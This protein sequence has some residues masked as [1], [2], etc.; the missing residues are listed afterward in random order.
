MPRNNLAYDNSY[1]GLTDSD[2]YDTDGI[3]ATDYVV[4]RDENYIHWATEIAKN[5]LA[6]TELKKGWNSYNANRIDFDNIN[7]AY[8][9]LKDLYKPGLLPPSIIPTH[10]GSI[11]LEW[12]TTDADLEI[13]IVDNF[14]F[15][16]FFSSEKN[17]DDDWEDIVSYDLERLTETISDYFLCS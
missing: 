4:I 2:V 13:E 15:D 6:L 17:P 8:E 16:V 9:F 1:E 5:L 11:Q 12:H 14:K 7:T 10:S 3:T